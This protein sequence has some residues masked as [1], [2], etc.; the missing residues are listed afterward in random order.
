MNTSASRTSCCR[1]MSASASSLALASSSTVLIACLVCW[2]CFGISSGNGIALGHPA[3]KPLLEDALI[4]PPELV[5]NV[6][7]P[8][9]QR[10]RACSIK[11]YQACLRDLGRTV[12]D[13][14]Q[15]HRAG[16]LDVT[17]RV[18]LPV[19]HVDDVRLGA[20]VEQPLE[21]VDLDEAHRVFGRRRGR[22]GGEQHAGS[23]QDA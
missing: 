12:G 1:A 13:D 3:G 11:D 15:R 18:G 23:R 20:A 9:G 14:S 22:G 7:G 4:A 10:V 6:A 17:L 8:P 19:P 2:W 5:Q 21:L 16:T